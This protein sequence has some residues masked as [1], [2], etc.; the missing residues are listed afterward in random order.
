[1]QDIKVYVCTKY[2]VCLYNPK[3]NTLVP[4]TM[5]DVRGE[6]AGRQDFAK[7]APVSLVLVSTTDGERGPNEKFGGTDAGYVSQNIYLACTALGLQTVARATMDIDAL[8]KELNLGEKSI[9]E[10]NHPIGYGK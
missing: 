8:K 5:N 9:I 1:M 6:V 10:L 4:V 3:E 7:A 2:G